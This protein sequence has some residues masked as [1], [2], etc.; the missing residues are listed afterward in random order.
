MFYLSDKGKLITPSIKNWAHNIRAC[1][2]LRSKLFSLGFKRFAMRNFNQDPI[3]NFF[4]C[5]RSHGVRNT[6][7]NCSAFITTFKSLLVNNLVSRRSIGA[8]C[9]ED[10]S[11]GI[12]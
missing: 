9:E 12:P 6:N 3:E 5:I 8:N 11:E 4:S 2:Y 1:I 10:E 7:P